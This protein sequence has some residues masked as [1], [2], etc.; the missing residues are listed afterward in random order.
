MTARYWSTV[1]AGMHRESAEN[2]GLDPPLRGRRSLLC[3]TQCHAHACS[4][5]Q[6]DDAATLADDPSVVV[7]A[8]AVT[9]SMILG[10]RPPTP[11]RHILQRWSTESRQQN[12]ALAT[13]ADRAV[14][15]RRTRLMPWVDPHDFASRLSTVLASL[16]S[17]RPIPQSEPDRWR[18]GA[19]RWQPIYTELRTTLRAA[20]D[21]EAA[22]AHPPHPK[23][24]EWR[25]HGLDLDA[26]TLGAQFKQLKN[27]PAYGYG[28]EQV[29]FAD[30]DTS[31]LRKALIDL[32]GSDSPNGL[33][34]ALLFSCDI[35]AD[36]RL[37]I[38]LC[39]HFPTTGARHEIG[40]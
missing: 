40:S 32:A 36:D 4:L 12:C 24:A 15:A 7:W 5:D 13:L 11:R 17:G 27:N 6:M 31:G 39:E 37:L 14:D 20:G 16:L 22:Q 10:Y 21:D 30:T 19:F 9:A 1:D 25:S 38:R 26:T 2:A 28:T 34:R 23:T 29:L 33:E 3:G 35:T 8:E 18:A